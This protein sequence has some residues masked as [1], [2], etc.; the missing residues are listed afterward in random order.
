LTGFLATWYRGSSPTR[1]T[2]ISVCK[3]CNQALQVGT[4]EIFN[5][6]PGSAIYVPGF[7][8]LLEDADIRISMD[9][10][11]RFLDNI[12]VERLWRSVK[13]EEICPTRIQENVATLLSHEK[14][15]RGS[16]LADRVKM[17]RLLKAGLYRS[18]LQLVCVLGHSD[19]TLRRWWLLKNNL[20]PH[21]V[22]LQE[23]VASRP[24]RVF[25]FDEARF[26]LKTDYRRR[27]CPVGGDTV[28]P[29]SS[30]IAISGYGY[31]RRYNP[32]RET[33]SVCICPI[34]MASVF[35][36]SLIS[37]RVPIPMIL[38]S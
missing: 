16:R 28:R 17:L 32:I 15:L 36:C 23:Q 27:W 25:A 14:R 2:P 29:G 7:H 35:S 22:S 13:Y 19:R 20:D 12:F 1:W 4:S 38:S 31:T 6:D 24:I 33:V 34:W 37:W 30:R 26:G 3:H 9:G 18:H 11:G 10:R 21:L 8:R 5:T